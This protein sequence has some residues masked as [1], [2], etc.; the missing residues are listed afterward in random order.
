[1][2]EECAHEW[3][4][5][6]CYLHCRSSLRHHASVWSI[7]LV[8]GTLV[9]TYWLCGEN[10]QRTVQSFALLCGT[11]EKLC[12]PG[13]DICLVEQEKLPVKVWLKKRKNSEKHDLHWKCQ[14]LLC[15]CLDYVVTER[16]YFL[17]SLLAF[18][19]HYFYMLLSFLKVCHQVRVALEQQKLMTTSYLSNIIH[20]VVFLELAPC[21]NFW[22]C[23]WHIFHL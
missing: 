5:L 21:N 17:L 16:I 10:K 8:T 3:G 19:F 7:V 22:K 14:I 12:S 18:F 23:I 2:S 15:Y 9:L 20:L 6:L 1:M 13:L 11:L 4:R